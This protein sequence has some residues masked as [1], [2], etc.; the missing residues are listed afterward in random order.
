MVL[1]AGRGRRLRPI[2]DLVPKPALRLL[3]RR[4]VGWALAQAAEAGA[5][6]VVANIWHL[7]SLMVEALA[8]EAHRVPE[9]VTSPEQVL[10]GGAGGIALARE[11][12]LL[13]GD[14]PLLVLN[15][16]GVFHFDLAPVFARHSAA[17]DLVTMGLLPHLDPE[18]WARVHLDSHGAVAEIVAPG[19]PVAGEVPFLYPGV[20]LVDRELVDALPA[21]PGE[22]AERVWAP[23]RAAGRFGGAVI[24]GHWREVGTPRD[25]LAAMLAL[26]G[27]RS[28]RH[29]QARVAGTAAVIRSMVG[30]GADVDEGALLARSIV[31]GGARVGRGARIL[32]SVVLGAVEVPPGETVNHEVRVG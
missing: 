4:L 2:S 15:G 23:A 19:P 25:Y 20:M 9:L 31:T 5:D 11:R 22:V 21:G 32:G 17:G 29:P 30:P 18:R 3:D 14:G 26:V 24:A 28:W 10:M 13:D 27:D 16:D 8:E 1:A 12:G 7:P 6:R